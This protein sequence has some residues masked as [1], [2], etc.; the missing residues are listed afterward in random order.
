MGMEIDKKWFAGFFV[1]GVVLNVFSA[2]IVGGLISAAAVAVF[3]YALR[4]KS[5]GAIKEF[6]SGN[7]GGICTNLGYIVA[8]LMAAFAFLV[9]TSGFGMINDCFGR[10]PPHFRTNIL[11]GQCEFVELRCGESDP[12][13]YSKDCTKPNSE[14]MALAGNLDGFENF[15]KYCETNCSAISESGYQ[16]REGCSRVP[17]CKLFAN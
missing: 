2:S 1:F 4:T 17:E 5:L 8:I 10:V 13:F 7:T 14:K 11:T 12:W 3:L 15:K 9:V 6:H 16:D